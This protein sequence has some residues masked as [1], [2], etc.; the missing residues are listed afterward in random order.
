MQFFHMSSGVNVLMFCIW[1]LGPVIDH[2]SL[3]VSEAEGD[4]TLIAFEDFHNSEVIL[5]RKKIEVISS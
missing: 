5:G 2:S 4:H 3:A 1:M